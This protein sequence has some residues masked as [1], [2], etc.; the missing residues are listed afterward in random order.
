MILLALEGLTGTQDVALNAI[1]DTWLALYGL[2][3]LLITFSKF[4]THF[5][6]SNQN[7]LALAKSNIILL[8]ICECSSMAVLTSSSQDIA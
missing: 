3:N 2:V 7:N 8:D 6:S 5:S 4:L 1:D